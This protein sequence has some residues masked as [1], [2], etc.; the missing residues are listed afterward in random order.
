MT[1]LREL[2][3]AAERLKVAL[4]AAGLK[5]IKTDNREVNLGVTP[6]LALARQLDAHL[7]AHLE[8]RLCEQ[9]RVTLKPDTTYVFTVDETCHDCVKLAVDGDPEGNSPYAAFVPEPSPTRKLRPIPITAARHIAEACGYDQVCIIGR[10]TD[11]PDFI[12]GPSGEHVT[13]YGINKDHCAAAARVGNTIKH[14]IMGW[15]EYTMA[16]APEPLDVDTWLRQYRAEGH[17]DR[18]YAYPIVSAAFAAGQSTSNPELQA[19]ILAIAEDREA[20]YEN[21]EHGDLVNK[22][23]ADR[24]VFLAETIRTRGHPSPDYT[25]ER[26]PT[27]LPEWLD[28]TAAELIRRDTRSG[29]FSEGVAAS[30]GGRAIILREVDRRRQTSIDA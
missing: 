22:R 5:L 20:G 23:A 2:D 6:E 7:D 3:D 4:A 29:N 14:K 1:S 15:P 13:T 27:A 10:R 18:G 9:H 25:L 26:V 30:L 28:W 21:R 17:D 16:A 19:T 12:D 11:H 8:M 24:V